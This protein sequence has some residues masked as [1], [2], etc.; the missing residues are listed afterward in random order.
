MHT[1]AYIHGY[2]DRYFLVHCWRWWLQ[3]LL[4]GTLPPPLIQGFPLLLFVDFIVYFIFGFTFVIL[5]SLR[6][7][8]LRLFQ[9][10]QDT[11]RWLINDQWSFLQ[12]FLLPT[13]GRILNFRQFFLNLTEANEEGRADWQLEYDFLDYYGLTSWYFPTYYLRQSP[14]LEN[15]E[16]SNVAGLIASMELGGMPLEKFL[17][18]ALFIIA[19]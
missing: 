5:H 15:M 17:L 16:L 14:G 3:P 13:D 7:P 11:G 10:D 4:R 8:G 12:W 2:V 6:N 18:V 1:W 19:A 9:F